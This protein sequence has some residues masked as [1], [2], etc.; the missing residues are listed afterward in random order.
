MTFRAQLARCF[1][2]AIVGFGLLSFAANA[3][4]QDSMQLDLDFRNSLPRAHATQEQNG[5]ARFGGSGQ[6]VRASA[7]RIEPA[8]RRVRWRRHAG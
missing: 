3:L 8:R 1:Q 7:A 5:A 2:A 6:N 4:A